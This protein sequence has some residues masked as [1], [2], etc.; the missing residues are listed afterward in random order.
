MLKNIAGQSEVH[1]DLFL[2]GRGVGEEYNNNNQ[3]SVKYMMHVLIS[4]S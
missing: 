4:L 1:D 3:C 2:Q